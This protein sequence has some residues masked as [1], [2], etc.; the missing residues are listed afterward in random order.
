M[1]AQVLR[2]GVLIGAI[3]LGMG[4]WYY[5]TGYEGWQ[6]MMFTT[7]AFAQIWQA[8]GI[9][10]GSD[11]LLKV[12][13]LSNKPLL[14]LALIVSAAQLAAVYVPALQGYLKTTPLALPDLLWAIAAGAIVLVYAEI[15][16]WFARRSNR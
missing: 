1:G 10:S 15:E 6:T 12:G 5:F 2:F 14:G 11:S 13:L 3:S 16:K 7:L 4:A 8:L 9:R